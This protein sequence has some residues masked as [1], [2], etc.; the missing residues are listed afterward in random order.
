MGIKSK[1]SMVE[2]SCPFDEKKSGVAS[3]VNGR[4]V[5]D[6]SENLSNEFFKSTT[7]YAVVKLSA[8]YMI[9]ISKMLCWGSVSFSYLIRM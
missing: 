6:S 1:I 8:E 4:L 3:K 2:G 9:R 5:V 7:A